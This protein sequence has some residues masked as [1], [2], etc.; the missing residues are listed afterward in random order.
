MSVSTVSQGTTTDTLK[1]WSDGGTVT[2][3]ESGH[4]IATTS[5]ASTGA[6]AATFAASQNTAHTFLVTDTDAGNTS[7]MHV[8]VGTA[9]AETM[10]ALGN[11]DFLVGNGGNDTYV[12]NAN[13]TGTKLDAFRVG[14]DKIDFKGFDSASAHLTQ[15]DSTHWQIADARHTDTFVVGNGVT[16]H[17]SDYFFG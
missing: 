13:V 16:L 4:T 11:G 8:V 14:H 6:W 1:G 2:V 12:L 9:K 10:T 5:V 15:V 3:S 17:A 7:T